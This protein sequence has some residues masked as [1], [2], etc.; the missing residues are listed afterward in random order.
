MKKILILTCLLFT[1]AKCVFAQTDSSK[2]GYVSASLCTPYY[3]GDIHDYK[4][5]P[6]AGISVAYSFPLKLN[7]PISFIMSVSYTKIAATDANS[8]K[9][10]KYH[11]RGLHFRSPLTEFGMRMAYDFRRNKRLKPNISLGTGLLIFNPQAN[12]G[13]RWYDLQAYGTEGQNLV[14]PTYPKPYKLATPFASLGVGAKYQIHPRWE[15]LAETRFQLTFT[16]Y[17][18]DI[19]TVY[20]ESALMLDGNS[21]AY[22]LSDRSDPTGWAVSDFQP[23]GNPKTKD[24]YFLSSVG[25]CY[26]LGKK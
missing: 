19:S 5:K 12:L 26:R 24:G 6:K 3:I 16:D 15:I 1:L 8:A 14:R 10:D 2:V 23:R 22:Q 9:N 18:D 17:L 20:P 7:S 21:I 13:G 4:Q 11:W 25:I